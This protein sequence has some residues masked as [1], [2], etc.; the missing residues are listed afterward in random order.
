M[1]PLRI[2]LLLCGALAGL[3]AGAQIGPFPP[4]DWP[5]TRQAD[6]TVHYYVTGGL[7]APPSETWTPDLQVLTGG[8]QPTGDISIGGFPGL[9][10]LGN[11]LNVADVAFTEWADDEVIDI[12]V[13]AYGDA[14]LFN[15][16]GEPRNFTFL[17]GVLPDLAFPVGG[18][19]AVEAR[20]R[21]WNWILFRIPNGFRPDGTR[22]VGSVPEGAVA[23]AGGV[24]GGTI[25]FEAVQ[26][27]IVRAIAFG[28]QG[29][30]GEPEAINV[31]SPA[32][33]C[34][35]EPDT[36]LVG[37]NVNTSS[38]NHL[39]VLNDGDQ[40]VT[41]EPNVGPANDKRTAVRAN[42]TGNYL[43]FGITD[44]YLG[45]SCNDPR[46]VKVCVEFYDDPAFAGAEVRFGPEAYA[47]DDQGGIGFYPGDQRQLL[48]G[49]G[50]WIKRSWVVPAVSLKGINTGTLTGGPRFVSEN[51][52]VFVSRVDIAVFRVGNH[53]LAGQDPL[54]DCFTDPNICTDAYGSFAE[55]DLHQNI[56]NGLDLG[57]SG[58]DQVM[59]EGEA[60]PASDKRN[61]IRP[62]RDEGPNFPNFQHNYLNFAITDE[63]LGPTSQ[64]NA[65]L[66]ICVTYYDDPALAGARFKPEVYQS[67]RNGVTGI[68]GTPDSFNVILEGTDQW[69]EAYWEIPDM[70]FLGVNQGPQAAARFFVSDK[71]FFS[72]IRY[73]VIRPC[74]PHA[75]ENA[76]AACK[77]VVVPA[78]SAAINTEGQL[79]I[80]WPAGLD[81]ILESVPAL[82]GTWQPVSVAP[83]TE[84]DQ[85]VV[86]LT[87]TAD[88]YYRL[89][90]P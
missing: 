51:G 81:Y 52:Q 5:T 90:Q 86:R 25:R 33:S 87:P 60:G 50:A 28:P 36:N 41:V 69:R 34:D 4:T 1:R 13:Q 64:P 66:A 88:S 56:R 15:S 19:V 2:T 35:P 8:D 63:A 39:V 16:A 48:A 55:L 57:S 84:G 58:G 65:N 67:D 31:F 20:N 22:F 74:G 42:G 53:P 75:G 12:L 61:G 77:P 18:Q 85:S 37:I 62:A 79:E 7:L 27:L 26:N 82:T 10:A 70:K 24:N 21:K 40:T 29:A 38:T 3:S 59:V 6:K 17:T 78:L 83:V 89:R 11:Y 43:N 76:L 72:R 45:L 73:A 44:N 30:F 49:S 23:P 54:A 47:T 14:A 68:V 9:K 32:D 80:R 46:T 71:V